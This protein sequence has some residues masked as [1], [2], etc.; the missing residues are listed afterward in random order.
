MIT[1]DQLAQEI[2]RV[3]GNHSLGAGALAEKLMPF[4]EAAIAA[5]PA[6]AVNIKPLEWRQLYEEGTRYP[7][8]WHGLGVFN[9]LV[10]VEQSFANGD[11]Y[12]LGKGYQSLKEAKAAAQADYEIRI[13]SALVPVAAEPV[14][15]LIRREGNNDWTFVRSA[16]VY[17]DRYERRPLFASPVAQATDVPEGLA[18]KAEGGQ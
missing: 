11:F 16:A 9:R 2:R 8:A 5:A 13:R 3:D 17:S 18:P 10:A 14:G 7:K 15:W 12:C 6:E 4:I 1:I